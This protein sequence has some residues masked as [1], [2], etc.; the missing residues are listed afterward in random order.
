MAS[1]LALCGTYR[2][3]DRIYDEDSIED[4]SVMIGYELEIPKA[5]RVELDNG[6]LAF[7]F[8]GIVDGDDVW[9]GRL[10][11][12]SPGNRVFVG[13]MQSP[14]WPEH[15]IRATLWTSPDGDEWL[16]DGEYRDPHD[17]KAVEVAFVF[18][19]DVE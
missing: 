18:F 12:L 1:S 17:G 10:E 3:R 16:L 11:S 15:P 13:S 4:D 19:P 8:E 9:Q 6:N 5:H 2:V 7:L 14:D